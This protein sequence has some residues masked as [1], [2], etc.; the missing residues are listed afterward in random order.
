[1]E[2]LT[3]FKTS[4][5]INSKPVAAK[6]GSYWWL[7]SV[8]LFIKRSSTYSHV[9]FTLIEMVVVVMIVGI[10]SAIVAPSWI[11]FVNQ[12]RVNAINSSILSSLQEAQQQAKKTK[13]SYSVSFITNNNLPQVAIEPAKANT[14]PTNWQPLGQNLDIKPGQVLLGTNISNAP[15]KE[16]TA[17]SSMSYGLSTAQT[18]IFDYTGSLPSNADLGLK[19]LIVT[20]A[21]PQSSDPTQAI[22]STRRC[23]KVTTLLGAMQSGQSQECNAS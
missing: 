16:N 1:M 10:L 14:P 11:G 8:Q 13:L 17:V 5:Q 20:V 18:I 19:G 21:V 4:P 22:D 12:R 7:K 3:L 9:G 15:N 6:L 2:K 23:I